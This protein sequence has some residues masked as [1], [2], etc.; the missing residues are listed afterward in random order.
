MKY[1]CCLDLRVGENDDFEYIAGLDKPD[2]GSIKL[3]GPVLIFG[4]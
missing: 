3:E 4:E 2:E 1:S